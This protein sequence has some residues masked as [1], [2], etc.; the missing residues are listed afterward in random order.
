MGQNNHKM[1]NH[2]QGICVYICITALCA[3][4]S[5]LSAVGWWY[6]FSGGVFVKEYIFDILGLFM[7]CWCLGGI[8]SWFLY[9]LLD[10][11]AF[12]T[13]FFST[14]IMLLISL[15]CGVWNDH[16]AR[17]WVALGLYGYTMV[18]MPVYYIN[19]KYLI[20]KFKITKRMSSNNGRDKD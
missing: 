20:P 8:I 12:C 18:C 19:S 3:V 6:I 4:L 17:G 5:S 1:N 10:H 2:Y 7:T 15:L 16:S 11:L 14:L 9:P 13:Y